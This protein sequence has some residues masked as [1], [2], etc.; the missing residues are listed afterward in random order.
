[1]KVKLITYIFA[2]GAFLMSCNDDVFVPRSG[3]VIPPEEE[4]EPE[5]KPQLKDSLILKSLVYQK[6]S[7]EIDSSLEKVWQ[8][9]TTW[10]NRGDKPQTGYLLYNN[11]NNS[12]IRISNHTYYVIS[13]KTEQPEIEIPGINA[14]G[15][16][17]LYGV[18]IP[19]KFGSTTIR[20]QYMPGHEES[21][22]L[23]PFSS[24]T[25]TI[26]VLRKVVKAKADI[27]YGVFGYPDSKDTNWVE[28]SVSQPVDIKVEWSDITPIE[29]IT[30]KE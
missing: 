19:F 25:A 3:E 13:W 26:Y 23:P 30:P 9:T 6:D 4:P 28:V 7:F 2:M 5:P 11:Y 10:Y 21:L 22:E 8:H 16:P 1:M 20:G 18:K 27:T 17:G 15:V 12:I 29:D 14:D 24:V